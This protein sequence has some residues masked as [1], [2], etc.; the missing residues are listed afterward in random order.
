MSTKRK[1][2]A[3]FTLTEAL[4]FLGIEVLT[5][6]RITPTP[7]S[8]SAVLEQHLLRLQEAFALRS[9]EAARV[10]IADALLAE[11]GVLHPGLRKRPRLPPTH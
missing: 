3:D 11:V 1:G 8:P 2:F 10:M 9:S 7:L 5:P 4:K 6:W